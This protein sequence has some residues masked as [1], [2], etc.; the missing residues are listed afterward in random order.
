MRLI[1]ANVILR[2]LL[3]DNKEMAKE[4]K[5]IIKQGAYTRNEIIAEVVYVLESVYNMERDAISNDLKAILKVVKIEDKD[6][7]EETIKIY[8]DTSL[9]F[10]DCVIIGRNHI[11]G[12]EVFSFD[13]KLNNKLAIK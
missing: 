1:D 9:D 11:L 13:K 4:S 5:E 10:V 12:E 3:N 7:L 8:K 2:F 6:A